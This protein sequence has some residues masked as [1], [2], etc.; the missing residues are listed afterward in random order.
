MVDAGGY[1]FLFLISG[2][3]DSLKLHPVLAKDETVDGQ[4]TQ[5]SFSEFDT[6]S[7]VFAY[8]TECIVNKKKQYHGEGTAQDFYDLLCGIGDSAVFIDAEEMIKVHIHTNHPGQVIEK[9]LEYGEIETLKVENMRRQH[10]SMVEKEKVDAEIAAEP[11]P[12]TPQKPYGFVAICMGDGIKNTFLDLGVDSVV[13]GGQ[14]MNPSTQNIIDGIAKVPAD[15][16]YI[17]PNNKNIYLVACQAA[18]TVTDKQVVVLQTKSV[19]QG[20]SAMLAFDPEAEE[21]VNTQAMTEAIGN[22]RT[23]QTTYAVRDTSIEGI[24]ISSGQTLALVDGKIIFS[25]EHEEEC[26]SEIGKTFSDAS[27]LTVFYGEGISEE[28]AARAVELLR[29]HADSMAEIVA[30]NGGQPIYDFIISAE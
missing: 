21:R 22:V 29:E 27:F 13:F 1:G 18:E 8:C 12:T 5:A 4:M 2:M 30:V 6:E 15:T 23:A 19:P 26:L 14:T 16:V 24:K 28:R 17:L 10:S 25:S 11:Q 3:L 9:A 7:I 20:I